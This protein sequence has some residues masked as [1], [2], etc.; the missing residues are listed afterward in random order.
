MSL[1][2]TKQWLITGALLVLM[3]A[4]AFGQ[5][6]ENMQWFAPPAD[7]SYGGGRQPREGFFA[8]AVWLRMSI[9]SPDATTIGYETNQPHDVY[10]SYDFSRAAKNSHTTDWIDSRM[11]DGMR[12]EV[13]DIAGHHGWMISGF[14]IKPQDQTFHPLGGG[15]MIIEDPSD[16]GMTQNQIGSNANGIPAQTVY[17]YTD[18]IFAK[19]I[20]GV[21]HL[22]IQKMPVVFDD[23]TFSH[24]V[25]TWSLEMNYVYRAHPFP[26]GGILELFGGVRY[27]EFDDM[28]GFD[29][30]GAPFAGVEAVYPDPLD[31]TVPATDNNDNNDNNNNNTTDG[32]TT[33]LSGDV[34]YTGTATGPGSIF[35]DAGFDTRAEN[36]ITGPQIGCKYYQSYG[37]WTIFTEGRFF[38]GFNRQNLKQKGVFGSQLNT[39]EY[40]TLLDD[41]AIDTIDAVTIDPPIYPW[42][43]VGMSEPLTFNH[44]GNADEW[45]PGVEFRLGA[46]WQLTD[47][48]SLQTSYD[49][50]W[51]DNVARASG[52]TDYTFDGQ[53][54]GLTTRTTQDV[55]TNAW[56]VGITLNR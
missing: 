40:Q 1:R 43:P 38:A 31:P 8:S 44:S 4:T 11:A 28:F 7:N 35:H 55:L 53:T 36:H 19:D 5:G 9:S 37:R 51:I 16:I 22:V 34:T 24:A 6:M 21:T 12:Y 46:N 27:M 13:G 17:G 30:R 15:E 26:Q 54:L 45:S 14:T 23:V 42:V 39:E 32:T 48:I 10:T 29:G 3:T 56:T 20:G 47:V 2:S 50:M 18:G 33:T 52:L 41:I 25:R 49:M